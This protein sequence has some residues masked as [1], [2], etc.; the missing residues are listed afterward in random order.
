MKMSV[1]GAQ[2]SNQHPGNGGKLKLTSKKV[3]YILHS[4]F[5]NA[6]SHMKWLFLWQVYK[7]SHGKVLYVPV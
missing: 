4:Y 5:I 7:H 2:T 1:N 3:G 6:Y